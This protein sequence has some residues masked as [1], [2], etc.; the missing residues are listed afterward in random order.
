MVLQLMQEA[1][2]KHAIHN[3]KDLSEE[4]SQF[5]NNINLSLFFALVKF[6]VKRL[7]E[8]RDEKFITK[9]KKHV[10]TWF[11]PV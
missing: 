7:G 10:R 4:K 2:K 9:A 3:K 1:C 5:K 11:E 6:V 8:K